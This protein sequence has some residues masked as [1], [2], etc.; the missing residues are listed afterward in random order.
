MDEIQHDIGAE[1][2]ARL[3]HDATRPSIEAGQTYAAEKGLDA[4]A[5]VPWE[6]LSENV[7]AGRISQ[8]EE[9][10]RLLASSSLVIREPRGT[11]PLAPCQKCGQ[12][13]HGQ[14]GEYPCPECGLPTLW[15][16]P[17]PES[18]PR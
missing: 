7:K 12:V 13:D 9:A 16:E 14:Y 10:L 18:A 8:A 6:A 15:D 1:A 17:E 5:F 3:L 11:V 4:R 2:F